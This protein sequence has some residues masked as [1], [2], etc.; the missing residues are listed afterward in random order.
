MRCPGSGI[1]GAFHPL[2]VFELIKTLRTLL[3]DEETF[4]TM[5]KIGLSNT[6]ALQMPR[7]RSKR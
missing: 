2:A 7:S 1:H 5:I 6:G 4:R 3:A